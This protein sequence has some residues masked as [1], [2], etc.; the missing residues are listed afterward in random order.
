[1]DFA[2]SLE[3]PHWVARLDHDLMKQN[4]AKQDSSETGSGSWVVEVKKSM[5]VA[6]RDSLQLRGGSRLWGGRVGKP[7]ERAAGR[8]MR[9]P[10]R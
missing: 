10:V 5:K 9:D 7:K 8:P 4:P 3:E 2:G 6:K 1:M